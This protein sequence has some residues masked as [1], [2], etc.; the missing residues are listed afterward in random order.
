MGHKNSVRVVLRI[1]FDPP[2]YHPPIIF[3]P[4]SEAGTVVKLGSRDKLQCFVGLAPLPAETLLSV[5][6]FLFY[7]CFII[8]IIVI[9]IVLIVIVIIIANSVS[10]F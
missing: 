8:A 3:D 4:K 7:Y 6:L 2:P 1:V 9:I 5:L 10:E